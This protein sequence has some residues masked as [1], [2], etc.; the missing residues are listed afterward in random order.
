MYI[1]ASYGTGSSG[2]ISEG[3]LKA[4][5]HFTWKSMKNKGLNFHPLVSPQNLLP[6]GCCKVIYTSDTYEDSWRCNFLGLTPDTELPLHTFLY[7]VLDI[8]EPSGNT[9]PLDSGDFRGYS[10]TLSSPVQL[11]DRG[12]YKCVQELIKLYNAYI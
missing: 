3:S 11:P 12:R 6:R 1:K 2:L 9:Q 5:S 10:F 4:R 8:V 7:V